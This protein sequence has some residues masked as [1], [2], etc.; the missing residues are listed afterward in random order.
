[1]KNIKK[2]RI[3]EIIIFLAI[4]VSSLIVFY[5]AG[6]AL[7][8]QLVYVRDNLIKAVEDEFEIKIT[9]KSISPSFFDKI[10][11]RDVNIYN[12]ATDDKIAHFSQLS[13]DY[14]LI[15]LI[16]KD[17]TSVVASLGVYD[18]IIDF[19][20]EKNKNI[21][22]KLNTED[23]AVDKP[24]KEQ[25]KGETTESSL[26]LLTI[27]EASSQKIKNI[28]PV[29]IELK[30]LALNYS[31]KNSNS[32]FYTSNGKLTLNSG[33]IDVYINSG[34]RYSNFTQTNFPGFSTLININGSFYPDTA[35]A[36]S[37]LN[38]SNIKIGNIHIDKFSVFA[39]YLDKIASVT[40]LQDIQPIDV[41]VSW[42]M[43]ENTGSI[44]LECNE[45][46]PLSAVSPSEGMDI[47][48]ELKDAA[49]TGH[50]NLS[51]SNI[52]KLLW[53][54]AFSIKLP[55]FQ[56]AGNKIEKSLLSFKADGTDDLINLKNLKLTNSD[57]NLSAQGSYKIKEILP[58]FYLN[59]SKFKLPS[60]EN[61]AMNLNVS[62]NK[63]KIFLKIPR[64]DIGKASL[65][66]IQ[67]VLEKKAGKTDIY[68]SG[69]DSIGGFSFDGTWTHTS[70]TN[71]KKT[72][73]YLELHGAVDSISIE[74]IYNGVISFT[75]LTF[76]GQNLLE[77]SINPV[78]M[79]SE[80]YIS[81]DFKQFSY[82]VIQAILA[83]NSKNGFYSLFSLQGNESS[84]DISNIDI[85][86]NNM[87][88]RGNIN[89]SFEKDSMIFDS[90]L[91]LNDISYKVSGLFTDEIINIYGD[92][93]LNI[94]ILKDIEKKLKGT[95]QVK[96]LPIPF[97]ASIFS[98]DTSFEYQDNTNW[99]LTCNYAKLE[100]LETD[101][102]KT[103]ESLEFYAE[104][105]AKP[106][107][108]FFHNVKAGIKNQQLE[109]TA[110][111]NLIPSSD[112][113]ISQYEANLSLLDK[114][115]TESFIF[116]SLFTV[117]DKIY[118]DGTCKIKDISLNRFLKKQKP[119][120]KIAAEFIFLGNKDSLSVKAD[121]KNISFNLNGQNIEGQASAFIDNDKMNLYESSFKWGIHKIDNIQA[122]IN[123]SEQKGALTF[124]YE[125]KTKD[126]KKQENSD[127]KAAF[128]FDF[129]STADKNT[130]NKSI[131]EK[132]VNMTSHF[133]I[134]MEISDW[135]LAG[136]KGEGSIKASLVKEPSIIALYAGNNDEIYGFKTDDGVVSLHIDESL[137][138]HLN[139]DGILSQNNINL[140]VS[141]IGIDLAKVI[142][143]IPNNNIIKF[144]GGNVK[145]DL[146]I[147]GTQKDPLFYGTLKG[148]KV[149]CTSP[150][151]SPD[152][153]GTVE[154]PIQFDGTLISVPYTIL[155]GKVGSIWGEAK[156]EF[157]GWIPYYTT[158]DCGVLENTQG[159]IKTKNIAFHADGRAQGK[160]RL[161]INP[162]LVTLE[163]DAYF[164]KGYFSVP[165]A[166]LQKQ[167]EQKSD[168]KA[169]TVFYMNLN[170]NFGKKSEFRYP[171]TEFP[172]LRALAYTENKP[173]NLI[174]D[175]GLGKFEMSGAAKIRTGEIF[176]IKR[177][178]YIKEGELK[179]LNSPF[180]QIE[181][182]ISV[183]AE[184]KDKMADGQPLTINLTAKEQHLDLERFRP[185]IT[186]SPPMAM[187]DSDTM[188][189]MGQVALGDLKNSNVLK[190]TLLNAS[191]IL[192]NIGLMK[193]LEQKARDVLHVDVFSVRSLLIQNVIL[194]NLFR[195]SNDKPLTIGNY[196]DNTSV[197]IGKYFGS[198]IYA[199]AM[200]H[201]SYYDPLSAK[202]DSVR[203]PIY[204]NL[205]FQPEIGFEM[206]TPFA[207]LR[208]HI[209]PSSLDSLFV[210]DTGLTLSWKFS[211]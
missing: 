75:G 83:S 149:F 164:D 10:K 77:A 159:L 40:T 210:S 186:T 104:G 129:I 76:P 183:R 209:A 61:M 165:F 211:Y 119:E 126:P 132:T 58:N 47:L 105:Y 167:N 157:I 122:F 158:V 51:F 106:K 69:K 70:E 153:Y 79:T 151:Y 44:N 135:I 161:E 73:D 14:R 127:T 143:F 7:E 193:K 180:Q 42:N 189:L 60:G 168:R 3:I 204:G 96:E 99:E 142:N 53:D 125:A 101:I 43:A 46:K 136:Q 55:K 41:K 72:S 178:F 124:L 191:D 145:G 87:N 171:S 56:I 92:Y 114:N 174:L 118:F 48:K 179:I 139:I 13:I 30:N 150:G 201:L 50:F 202:T 12:A 163:G 65:E 29:K 203:K 22:K 95:M 206:N 37:I 112:K 18:G 86:F 175:T 102:T 170:L 134:D 207:L 15:S 133:N 184:I 81:S 45:L 166:D 67:G 89:S 32:S 117:S 152:T 103:D 156:S 100:H 205:L 115:K 80:F 36:S 121:L 130:E 148:E 85:L 11:I 59:I 9:Y 107:E 128:S 54:T 187:S 38:F 94:N 137:P 84:F 108:V 188:N 172:F 110:A 155:H 185:V 49:F 182:I 141:N 8:K 62:S 197:Y 131:I 20:I 109:G 24:V 82:N 27:I 194:E 195:S 28:K 198:A 123:P 176:Y 19:N 177:N 17:F 91:T 1:V 88:L 97:I 181:P 199:D 6:K 31:N 64:A 169:K 4:V 208:W 68:L 33:K 154:I 66:N 116:N 34:L 23:R 160:I 2:I 39:S 190:E 147:N 57:I 144:S 5:P 71:S 200:L 111:L 93:G 78:Q 120:N 146:Q 162:K 196:F 35:S 90:L 98:A 173:F 21:L 113:N 192:A 74:N 140:S 25:K 26:D 63:N 138:L 16:K 52:E